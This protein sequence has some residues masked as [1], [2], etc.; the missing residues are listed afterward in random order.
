[1]TLD[2]M[3]IKTGINN[4]W[5]LPSSPWWKRLPIIRH[6][7]ALF[8]AYCVERHERAWS[9]IGIPTGYDQWIL[10]GLWHGYVW[11]GGQSDDQ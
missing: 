7:R 3:W 2:P 6:V 4:G 10:F 11:H 9:G 5:S 1:M 8:L